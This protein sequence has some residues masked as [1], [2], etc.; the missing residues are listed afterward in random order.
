MDYYELIQ[1][2]RKD[3]KLLLQLFLTYEHETK[4]TTR[5]SVARRTRVGNAFSV[6]DDAK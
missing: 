3:I 1:R 2:F 4:L 5:P 6:T